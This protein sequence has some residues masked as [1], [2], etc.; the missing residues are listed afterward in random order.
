MLTLRYMANSPLQ[1]MRP[2]KI[3]MKCSNGNKP[4]QQLLLKVRLCKI[5]FS[6]FPLGVKVWFWQ[7]RACVNT[8]WL[9]AMI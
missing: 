5:R 9:V 2:C 1:I 3:L 4:Q 6:L 7:T 8:V